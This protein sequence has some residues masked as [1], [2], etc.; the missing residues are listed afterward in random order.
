MQSHDI[1]TLQ[2]DLTSQWHAEN[3]SNQAQEFLGLITENH[4]CNFLL[5]HEEDVARREDIGFEPIYHA[6]RAI[7]GHNQR[8]NDHI[9]KIDKYLVDTLT[10]KTEGVPFNSETPGMMIDRLSILALKEYHMQEEVDRTDASEEHIA[11]CTHKVAVIK[12][13][14]AD[15]S[16]ALDQLLSEVADGT[17]SFRVYYQFKMYN[18]ASLNPQLREAAAK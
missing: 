15:L 18:D 16:L 12:Q 1:T 8:R 2:Q 6:K 17:R 14:I 9:E 10:P 13:Q 7:D 3:P 4:L 11:K 5:W